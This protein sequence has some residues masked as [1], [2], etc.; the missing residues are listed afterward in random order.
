MS[1]LDE[2]RNKAENC[3]RLAQKAPYARGRCPHLAPVDGHRR[4]RCAVNGH[5][6]GCLSWGLIIWGVL[7][8]FD[9]Y[10]ASR[11]LTALLSDSASLN[12]F[13]MS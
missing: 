10:A 9:Q 3:E 11:W 12:Y 13:N 4:A 2:Y 5:A 7:T 8:I 1:K 6:V